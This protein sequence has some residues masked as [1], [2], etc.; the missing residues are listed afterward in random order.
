VKRL[1]PFSV[2]LWND[3]LTTSLPILKRF[4]SVPSSP[5]KSSRKFRCF[6]DDF[7]YASLAPRLSL[8]VP[9]VVTL[10][11]EPEVSG[12]DFSFLGAEFAVYDDEVRPFLEPRF[13]CLRRWPEEECVNQLCRWLAELSADDARLIL[14]RLRDAVGA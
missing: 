4:L 12:Y 10:P 13:V 8:A 6:K 5:I 2:L 3:W 7:E 14:A 11:A 9:S 1:I